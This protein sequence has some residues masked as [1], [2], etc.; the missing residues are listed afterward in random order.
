MGALQWVE[1]KFKRDSD[2]TTEAEALDR[3]VGVWTYTEPINSSDT[4][5]GEWVK[6]DVRKDGK[7]I[8]YH[9]RPVDD[10]W[11]KG[12]EVDYK[13]LSGK[14]TDTGKRWHGIREGDTVI[15]GIYADGHLVLHDLTSSYKSTGVMQRGDKN[16][17][18]K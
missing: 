2:P 9:A 16:P 10:G 17:F 6:W 11:G 14:Y 4:F 8:A 5:P 18:T 7:M 13:V 1:S 15:A 12:V 3:M